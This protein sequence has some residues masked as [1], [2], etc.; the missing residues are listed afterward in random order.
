MRKW[1][2]IGDYVDMIIDSLKSEEQTAN[3]GK[4]DIQFDCKLDLSEPEPKA[5]D[6]AVEEKDAIIV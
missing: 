4:N 2:R 6:V 1:P 5:V 3:T